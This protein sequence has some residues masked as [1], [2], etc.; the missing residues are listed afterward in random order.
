[1]Q[2]DFI[3]IGNHV[4]RWM[5]FETCEE[6]VWHSRSM[7]RCIKITCGV[8]PRPD[9]LLPLLRGTSPPQA[10]T[11]RQLPAGVVDVQ[12][13]KRVRDHISASMVDCEVVRCDKAGG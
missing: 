12:E 4:T 10:R 9:F 13:E 6:H 2:V 5:G 1:M 8:W 11:I 7:F 3:E